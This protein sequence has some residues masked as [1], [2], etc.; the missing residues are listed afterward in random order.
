MLSEK[1]KNIFSGIAR[2]ALSSVLLIWLLKKV[3][4]EQTKE[5]LF[6]AD[7]TYLTY[8]LGIFFVINF[9][10]LTRWFLL[11]RALQLKVLFSSVRDYF[12]IGLFFNLFLPT[13]IGGDVVKIMGLCKNVPKQRAKVVASVLLDRLSG[14]LG[15]SLTALI[16]FFVG[17]QLISDKSLLMLIVIMALCSAGVMAVLFNE[18]IYS[19]GCKV[20]NGFPKVKERLMKLHYDVVLL[21][22]KRYVV[23]ITIGLSILCQILLAFCSFLIA[24]ALHQDI[25]IIY[26][27]IFMPLMCIASAF[28]SIGGLGVREAGAVVLFAKVG[29]DA[30]IAASISLMTFIFMA[31]I[32]LIG[33]V[34]YVTSLSSGRVQCD[35]PN[36]SVDAQEARGSKK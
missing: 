5:V 14:F 24:K 15:M 28:P 2:I 20:F 19:F 23:F 3:D 7:L 29:V 4:I 33:G 34:I 22:E 31:V 21:K 13:A 25:R 18:R 27:F 32:G 36:A 9:I 8:A 12:F 30:G 11:V 26:F 1:Q 16:A 6:N 10:L 17:Y 35:Q